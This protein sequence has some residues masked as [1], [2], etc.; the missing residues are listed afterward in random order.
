[1]LID[2]G[3]L[4]ALTGHSALSGILPRGIVDWMASVNAARLDFFIWWLLCCSIAQ[5]LFVLCH[6]A[7]RIRKRVSFPGQHP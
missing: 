7:L 4:V 5:M 3:V 1:M 6:L 2:T